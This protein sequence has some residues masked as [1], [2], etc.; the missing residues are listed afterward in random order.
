M[1]ETREVLV[2]ID[3][4][5]KGADTGLGAIKTK[6]DQATKGLK[7][8]KKSADDTSKSLTSMAKDTKV[9]G[10][11][12]NS[13]SAGF[14]AFRGVIV[15]AIVSLK[16]FKIALAATGIG[17]LVIAL[18]AVITFLT[19]M[20]TGVDIVSKAMAQLGAAVA[21]ILDR[22]GALGKI[23]IGFGKAAIKALKGDF[24][25]AM[26]AATE[27]SEGL[28]DV[29]TGIGEEIAND[30]RLAGEFA[31]AMV[32]LELA[33]IKTIVPFAKIRKAIAQN[34]L[35]SKN[36]EFSA[37]RRLGAV[38]AAGILEEGLLAKQIELQTELLRIEAG[39]VG[40]GESLN[41]ELRA[42]AE[43]EAKLFQLQ[44]ASLKKRASIA[45]QI[46]KFTK[47]VVKEEQEA[48]LIRQ[49]SVVL[50]QEAADK[51]ELQKEVAHI[52]TLERL[53]I[54]TAM[55]GEASIKKLEITDAEV[56]AILAANQKKQNAL[57]DQA[58]AAAEREKLIAQQKE[59]ALLGF[60]QQ[61]LDAQKSLG[62]IAF[63]FRQAVAIKEIFIST[64]AAIIKANEDIPF[65]FSIAVGIFYAALGVAQAAAVAG[66]QFF[67]GGKIKSNAPRTGD[68]VHIRAN[69]GEVILNESQQSKLGGAATFRKIGVPGFQ[70]GGVV[71]ASNFS[72]GGGID[73]DS[74]VR[75]IK[76]LKVIVSVEDINDGQER[77]AVVD[78]KATISR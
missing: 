25:G 12:V 57:G 11:S 70:G 46:E 71:P 61:G 3:I 72:F 8:T 76:N 23:I 51:E 34:L 32:E 24:K 28:K 14:T 21:V 19:R 68:H 2:K 38:Q 6:S 17:L 66:V 63:K 1:A 30:V 20:Q 22:V 54:E 53:G 62:K 9:F 58:A 78:D 18:G 5:R 16:V 50:R 37:K 77:V 31:D 36:Q 4:D 74:V 35:D 39:K 59:M 40:L 10:I 73:L 49:E 7:D 67:R 29:F 13:L 43:I 26:E 56:T 47:A 65:P 33:T 27:A 52:R 41:D 60:V 15:K 75:S 69:P 45:A 64:R 55:F 44:E 48:E 42:V